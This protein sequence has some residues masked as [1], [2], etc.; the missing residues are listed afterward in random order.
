[1]DPKDETHLS[2]DPLDDTKVWDEQTYPLIPVGKMVLNKNPE[3]F[4]E[5]VEKVAFSPSNLLE[6]AELSDDKICKGALTFTV[7]HKKKNWSRISQ[8]ND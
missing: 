6:G 8:I 7:I 5:Q 1:M 2:Y 3:N 4:M